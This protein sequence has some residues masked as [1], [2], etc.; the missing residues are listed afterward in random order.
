MPLRGEAGRPARDPGDAVVLDELRGLGRADQITAT[1]R[2]SGGY[3]ADAWLITYT[4]GTQLVG[5]TIT[6]AA[7]DVFAAEADGLAAL[8]GIGHLATPQVLA[9][10]GRMLLLEA[11]QPRDDS[12]RSWEQPVSARLD[13]SH[14]RA[15]P[16]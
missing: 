10:T 12:E 7:P 8:R 2:L 14:A 3:Q 15:A 6:G 13:R 1:S 11:L 16:A 9:V 5:K 4:D